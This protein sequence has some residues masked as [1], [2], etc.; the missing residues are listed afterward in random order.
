MSKQSTHADFDLMS[1]FGAPE[2]IEGGVLGAND[3][4]HSP[5]ANWSNRL[6]SFDGDALIRTSDNDASPCMLEYSVA[7]AIIAKDASIQDPI[8]LYDN[9]TVVHV[10][11]ISKARPAVGQFTTLYG[12]KVSVHSQH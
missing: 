4:E 6:T 9:R 3:Y 2:A 7:F 5:H 8:C 11:V 1:R 12:A 10:R